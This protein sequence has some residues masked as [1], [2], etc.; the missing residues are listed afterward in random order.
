MEV[1]EWIWR[2]F[3]QKSKGVTFIEH[4]KSNRVCLP[5][6]GD[7]RGIGAGL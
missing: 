7:Y 6:A 5:D 1:A 4:K 3:V 2:A